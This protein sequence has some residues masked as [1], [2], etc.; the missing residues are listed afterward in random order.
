MDAQKEMQHDRDSRYH[1]ASQIT[2]QLKEFLAQRMLWHYEAGKRRKTG[3]RFQFDLDLFR[4][5]LLEACREA[6]GLDLI[7][8]NTR[9]EVAI[10]LGSDQGFYNEMFARSEKL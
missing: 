8:A 1:F 7:P 9:L 2:P 5:F 3:Q 10:I 4:D 6:E